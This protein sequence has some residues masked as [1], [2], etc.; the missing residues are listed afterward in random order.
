MTLA[1][2]FDGVVHAYSKGWGEG[3]IYDPPFEGAFDG[4]RWLMEHEAVYILTS[5][6]ARQVAQWLSDVG[7][8]AVTVDAKAYTYSYNPDGWNGEFW[9]ERNMLLVTNRK[10][11]A[12][13]YIDDRAY[14]FEN[15]KKTLE[16]FAHLDKTGTIG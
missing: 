9:N 12:S 13:Y 15:W 2:D 1:V 16:D 3:D 10:L 14:K 7:G 6:D 8:F 5:R 11:A 4:L